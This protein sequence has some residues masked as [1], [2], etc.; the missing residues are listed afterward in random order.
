MEK[1]YFTPIHFKSNDEDL[2]EDLSWN[3][4]R[5]TANEMKINSN[6]NLIQSSTKAARSIV[7]FM[8]NN[9]ASTSDIKGL[10]NGR[11]GV[12]SLGDLTNVLQP[13][14]VYNHNS[15]S[16]ETSMILYIL[17][18]P[19]SQI[20]LSKPNGV[21]LEVQYALKQ[22]NFATDWNI[23]EAQLNELGMNTEFLRTQ[24]LD[25][26]G[27]CFDDVITFQM[28]VIHMNDRWYSSFIPKDEDMKY[29]RP[30]ARG[31]QFLTEIEAVSKGFAGYCK[32]CNH[33]LL[34]SEIK[35][36]N[37]INAQCISCN[38]KFVKLYSTLGDLRKRFIPNIE[39][40]YL[41][42]EW[43]SNSSLDELLTDMNISKNVFD[44]WKSSYNL[45]ST[46]L[47]VEVVYEFVIDILIK[48]N[49]FETF[50]S[51][52]S[53]GP[54]FEAV[55]VKY[56]LW[57][58]LSILDAFMFVFNGFVMGIKES[59]VNEEISDSVSS[60]SDGLYHKIHDECCNGDL[61]FFV[62]SNQNSLV[63]FETQFAL[64][65]DEE[66]VFHGS[67]N[68]A[69]LLWISSCTWTI[70]TSLGGDFHSNESAIYFQRDFDDAKTW[71]LQRSNS[72]YYYVVAS[73]AVKSSYIHDKNYEKVTGKE[74]TDTVKCYRLNDQTK[75]R[76]R[77]KWR[78]IE[79]EFVKM[80]KM[81]VAAE[82]FNL[83][84]PIKTWAIKSV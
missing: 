78:I 33:F 57:E 31:S 34:E 26:K 17:S 22:W 30:S 41:K 66:I 9:K 20:P 4:Q 46:L 29:I 77:K 11:A 28:F 75:I 63:D 68:R 18:I 48:T 21:V 84:Y 7:S 47:P 25:I 74:W 70:E 62:N 12:L 27:L 72:G 13:Q 67:G 60:S 14:I 42:L 51:L 65:D 23:I 2:D 50:S 73:F 49:T 71:G 58:N 40:K 39:T 82:V 69:W 55:N 59:D 45:N 79:G 80:E 81:S 32:S 8:Q 76:K 44:N 37:H 64:N 38:N 53:D 10:I 56:K 61:P 15:L 83:Q 16:H 6:A 5:V 54:F 24:L 35:S 19:F 36:I 3:I 1:F 52:I 43:T